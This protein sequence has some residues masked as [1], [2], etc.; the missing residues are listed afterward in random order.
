MLTRSMAASHNMA[1]NMHQKNEMFI[2]TAGEEY[3]RGNNRN[4]SDPA[5]GELVNAETAI[6]ERPALRPAW[7]FNRMFVPASA[8]LA[9]PGRLRRPLPSRLGIIF[10]GK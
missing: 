10:K 3:E 5:A 9:D 6:V 8:I 1:T 2:E 7:R 4:A